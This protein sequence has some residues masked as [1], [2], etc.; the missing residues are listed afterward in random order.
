MYN[1]FLYN[2]VSHIYEYMSILYFVFLS[3]VDDAS[4]DE[5]KI[6]REIISLSTSCSIQ[7]P[8]KSSLLAC[9]QADVKGESSG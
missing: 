6:L 2:D 3:C 8:Y 4:K 9:L 7:Q 1:M 5:A